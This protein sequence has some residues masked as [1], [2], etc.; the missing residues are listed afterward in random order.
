MNSPTNLN[1]I[2]IYLIAKNLLHLILKCTIVIRFNTQ[3][4]NVFSEGFALCE[5]TK[6]RANHSVIKNQL[7]YTI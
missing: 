1:N 4:H 3:Y 6:L 2:V 5:I 7:N